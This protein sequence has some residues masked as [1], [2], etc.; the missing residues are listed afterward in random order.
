MLAR[1]PAAPL[2]LEQAGTLV[3]TPGT[4]QLIGGPAEAPPNGDTTADHPRKQDRN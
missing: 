4:T 1:E 2:A 3:V